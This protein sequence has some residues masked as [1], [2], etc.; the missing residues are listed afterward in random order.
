[1]ALF[2]GDDVPLCG[3][4]G[5]GNG[6]GCFAVRLGWCCATWWAL[7]EGVCCQLVGCLSGWSR[8][9][10]QL[11]QLVLDLERRCDR[12]LLPGLHALRQHIDC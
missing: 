5:L 1:M 10:E 4:C 3:L 7:V 12:D 6:P 8:R 9:G 11:R 2:L